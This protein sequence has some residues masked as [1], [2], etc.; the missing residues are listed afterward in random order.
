MNKIKTWLRFKLRYWLGIDNLFSDIRIMDHRLRALDRWL[1][2]NGH[3][4]VAGDVHFR[5]GNTLFIVLTDLNG[6]MVKFIPAQCLD[7]HTL[8]AYIQMLEHELK[9]QR[10][11]FDGPRGLNEEIQRGLSRRP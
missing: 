11:W 8:R 2:D 10:F 1:G 7:Y 3:V 4:A 9:P 6:G 5:D